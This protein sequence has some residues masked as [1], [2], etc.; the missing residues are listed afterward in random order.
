[1][2]DIPA[3]S[4]IND[5][6]PMVRLFRHGEDVVLYD[7]KAHFAVI[8]SNDELEVLEA[9]LAGRQEEEIV[10]SFSSRLGRNPI[11]ELCGKLERLRERG[12]F[13]GGPAET[14]SPAGKEEIRNLLEY[15]DRNILLRKFCLEVTED[16]NFRCTYC[17]RTI[18]DDF[19]PHSGNRMSEE[20]AFMA[21]RYYFQKYTSFFSRL[22][23]EKK[24]L[25]LKIVPPG[26]S[27]Y[28][29]EPFLN[30]GLIQKTADFFKTLPWEDFSIGRESFH[31]TVNTN[32][33]IMSDEIL[34]FLVD[35]DVILFASL[36]GPEEEHDR[37]RVFPDGSGT[38]RLAYSNLL[39][40]REFNG[41]YF[42]R[43]VSL[44]GV[45]TEDHD[46]ERCQ[47][48][49]RGIGAFQ[50]RH[51]PA[52]Y[53][54][55]F[56][57][58]PEETV[59][60]GL[61]EFDENL[62]RFAEVAEAQAG[63]DEIDMECFAGLL[64]F[65]GLVFDNPSGSNFLKLSLTCPMGFDNLMAAANGDYLL[66]HKV[67]G[68]L[69]IGH[70]LKGLDF[71]KLVEVNRKYAGT[72]NSGECRSCWAVRFCRIC[73]AARMSG[74]GFINPTPQ[75][76]DVLR[77]D[78]AFRFACFLHLARNHPDILARIFQYKRDPEH[79]VGVIDINDF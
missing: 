39:K 59:R 22:S 15:Y 5:R 4:V 60:R 69:P 41:A 21:I 61:A 33:S 65:A 24:E 9:F 75:E 12:V 1:M 11:A 43:R 36:D 53:T 29:G 55:V 58:D 50:S 57:P 54:G 40:I 44:F 46:H 79:C 7:G 47:T 8:L 30:F 3:A 45:L 74:E 62:G 27:W 19:R 77:L 34:A 17:K 32:L 20:N 52:Q 48:F 28:G 63:R 56:V 13:T 42:R 49:N 6:Y 51:F 73:A 64:Q 38:F 70:C 71:E 72:V 14:V 2:A 31:F 37:C 25:L 66:C 78:I 10:A 16:C 76:C 68:N 67:S 35:N 18:A 26:L 23:D